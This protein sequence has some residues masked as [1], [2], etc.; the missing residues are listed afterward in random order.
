MGAA[1]LVGCVCALCMAQRP[2]V[3]RRY[4]VLD[5]GQHGPGSVL[6]TERSTQPSVLLDWIEYNVFN[7]WPAQKKRMAYSAEDI[8]AVDL[9]T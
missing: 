5:E 3:W 4:K 6:D 2:C 9:G 7:D 1:A 8:I